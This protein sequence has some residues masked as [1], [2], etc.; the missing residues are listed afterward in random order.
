MTVLPRSIVFI[1]KWLITRVNI[2]GEHTGEQRGKQSR[3][4]N[5]PQVIGYTHIGHRNEN[6][7]R[8][9]VFDAWQRA[10]GG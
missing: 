2:T 4:S 6:Q 5:V 10:K 7:D 1:Y 3:M 8:F 9:R